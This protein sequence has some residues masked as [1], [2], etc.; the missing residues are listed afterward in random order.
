VFLVAGEALVDF[1]EGPN[2]VVSVITRPR[3]DDYR[4]KINN[5]Y[6]LSG[7]AANVA[8][9]RGGHL[10]L[11]L[12]AAPRRVAFIGSATGITAGAA[13]LH[14]VERIDLIE[15]VPEVQKLA[16]AHF[17]AY[18]RDV[19]HDPRTHI[20]LEDGRNHLRATSETYD[21]IVADLF[22]PWRPGVGSMYSVDHFESVA[23]RLADG[24]VFCQWL[25]IFQLRAP[26]LDVILK[27]FSQVFPHATLWRGNFSGNLPRLAACAMKGPWTSRE[28]IEGRIQAL[29]GS[30]E[31]KWVSDPRAFWMLYAGPLKTALA[32]I[33]SDI[34]SDDFP[35]FEY[36]AGRSSRGERKRF[37]QNEWL[38]FSEH[39][40]KDHRYDDVAPWPNQG[41]EIGHL[42]TELSTLYLK[43]RKHPD[44]DTARNLRLQRERLKALLPDDLRKPDPTISEMQSL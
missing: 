38:A 30:V 22:V 9:E 24:G 44:N 28:T 33:D 8:V 41:R 31:D 20:I 5:N 34:N 43:N 29:A 16:S 7:S 21:V 26:E 14:G 37:L 27:T 12:H 6:T 25:P 35:V 15:L 42:Y 39:L 19:Y 13:V 18:N 36:L 1:A 23:D 10:P 17:G 2:G 11:L 32:T 4:I 3:F 40:G